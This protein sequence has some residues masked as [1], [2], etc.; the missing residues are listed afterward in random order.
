MGPEK[1]NH[2]TICFA[3]CRLADHLVG[4]LGLASG[5]AAVAAD[6]ASARRRLVGHLGR[7]ADFAVTFRVAPV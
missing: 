5:S 2:V 7:L 3:L 4:R 6:Q 1:F